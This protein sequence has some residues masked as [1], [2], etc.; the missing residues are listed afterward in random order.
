MTATCPQ[1]LR[2]SD[3]KAGNKAVFIDGGIHAREWIS[4]AVVT[5]F[6]NQFAENFDVESDD[7]KN[8]DW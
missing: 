6:I 2:I 5:Y 4:P 7:I 3:G 1:M 8:I